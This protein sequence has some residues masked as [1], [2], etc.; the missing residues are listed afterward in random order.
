MLC[1][2]DGF[3][4]TFGPDL[5]AR[6]GPASALR[7]AALPAEA[8]QRQRAASRPTVDLES[9]V[10]GTMTGPEP[11]AQALLRDRFIGVVRVGHPLSRGG[12][13]PPAMRPPGTSSSRGGVS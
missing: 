9:G 6:L 5:I 3:V 10:V 2:S 11:R 7:A 1:T 8:R 4:K 12:S 13:R